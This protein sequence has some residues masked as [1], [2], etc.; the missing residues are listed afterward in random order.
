MYCFKSIINFSKVL[1][2]PVVQ[3]ED[4]VPK[5]VYNVNLTFNRNKY[6]IE[7]IN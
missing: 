5:R 6:T 2:E 1:E 3:G 7:E 4:V